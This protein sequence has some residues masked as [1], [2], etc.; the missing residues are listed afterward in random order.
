MD[1]MKAILIGFV[2]LLALS[3]LH[4]IREELEILNQKINVMK[5]ENRPND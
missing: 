1:W 2:I 5:K 4:H 3:D